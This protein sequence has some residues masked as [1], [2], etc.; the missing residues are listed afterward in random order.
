[1]WVQN[2]L[3]FWHLPEKGLKCAAG[4]YH[5]CCLHPLTCPESHVSLKKWAGGYVVTW[6]AYPGRIIFC[7]GDGRWGGINIL[8]S[9]T[10]KLVVLAVTEIRIKCWEPCLLGLLLNMRC[11][12]H[13]F[14]FFFPF[15]P[16]HTCR[17][18]VPWP[19]IQPE[20]STVGTRYLFF[21][22]L[23]GG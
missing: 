15:W 23:I 10:K 6:G 3:H 14:F 8:D 13:S 9:E 2:I 11:S 4:W 22:F 12:L 18:L 16:H 7:Q 5:S 17:I 20:P 21:F 19:G 1:M